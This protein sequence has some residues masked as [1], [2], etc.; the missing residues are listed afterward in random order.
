MVKLR[1]TEPDRPAGVDLKKLRVIRE[2]MANEFEFCLD[3][4]F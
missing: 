2:K 1:M 4:R 3:T